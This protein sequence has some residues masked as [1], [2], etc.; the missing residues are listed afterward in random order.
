MNPTRTFATRSSKLPAFALVLLSVF[1]VACG[2]SFE[3]KTPAGFVELDETDPAYAYRAT[4][5]DGLVVAV[6]EV[7]NE[8][9]GELSFWARAVEN[10]LRQRGGYALLAQR[11][12]KT[13]EGLPGKQLRFGHDEGNQPH[14]YNVTL[15]VKDSTS[16]LFWTNSSLYV[17][18]AGGTKELMTRHAKALDDYVTSFHA[19]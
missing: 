8:P 15:F 19:K 2:Q 4:T 9:R 16:M 11:D 18:E 13:H 12:V 6:R 7:E 10:E 1:A 5:A 14:E 17:L 3:A